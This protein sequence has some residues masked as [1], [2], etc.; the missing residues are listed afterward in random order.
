[1]NLHEYSRDYISRCVTEQGAYR[2][3]VRLCDEVGERP[4]GSDAERR[5]AELMGSLMSEYGLDV[6]TEEFSYD[7]WER[8]ATS[9]R[10]SSSKGRFQIPAF[11]LGFCPPA[12]MHAPVVD[13]G[14]G[15]ETEFS[16]ADVRGRVA[17]V[18]S[19]TLPGTP[20]LHRSRKYELAVAAGAAA[21]AFY[22]DRPGGLTVAGSARL[23]ATGCGS[24]PAV[25]IGFEDAMAIQRADSPEME[26]ISECRG[27]DA[28]SL[29]TI[30]FKPGDIDEEIVVCGHID[31]WFS[32]GAVDNGSGV[33]SVVELARLLQ[34]YRLRRGVR[35]IAFGS[36]ELGILGSKAYV[37][38]RANLSPVKLV[39]NLD[40]PAMLDGRLT[41][42]TNRSREL[43]GYFRALTEAVNL[44]IEL[45]PERAL[46][47]DHAHFRERGI[48]SAQFIARS[49]TMGFAHTA[50]DTLD[51]IDAASFTIPLLIAG[52]TIIEAA[53]G[54]TLEFAQDE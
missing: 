20:S 32:P 48:P 45:R 46:H 22:I 11:P 40:C 4:S 7:G 53:M 28:T 52:T 36:E 33:V 10:Y 47:S 54:K 2:T 13:V 24:I 50:Y 31:S 27:I 42:I 29:N 38:T 41:I 23:D 3:L 17:L 1:M 37:E 35:F 19:A 15:S 5:G 26:I 34:P 43:H 51:K 6:E 44:D 30:G 9:V 18:S 16:E 49:A 8:G 25:G 12:K 39:L 21:F 14:T